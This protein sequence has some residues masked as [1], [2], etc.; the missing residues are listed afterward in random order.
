MYTIKKSYLLIIFLLV[1]V[2]RCAIQPISKP[3]TV[4]TVR[5]GIM[6]GEKNIEFRAENAVDVFTHDGSFLTS[7]IAGNRFLVSVIKSTAG[8]IEYRLLVKTVHDEQVAQ[9]IQTDV[10]AKGFSA[11]IKK[12][13]FKG[14][15]DG[16]LSSSVV[17]QVVLKQVF[18]TQD[19]A[20]RYRTNMNNALLTTVIPNFRKLP[21]GTVTLKNLNSGQMVESPAYLRVVGNRITLAVKVGTGFHFENTETR[22]Y[23]GIINFVIDRYGKL[24]MI[25]ELTLEAYLSGVVPSEMH[26]DF[27]LEALKAQSI[28]ARSYAVSRL[29]RQ[30]PLDPFD[31]CDDVHCQV[32]SGITRLS[33]N[34]DRAVKET[35]GQVLMYENSICETFYYAVC[36]GHTEHNENVW[37]GTP[38]RYLRGIFDL[39]Q[40]NVTVDEDFLMSESNMRTWIE[41]Q[42]NV[43][44]NV[45]LIEI[46]SYLEYTKK[47]FRW[48]VAYT[49]SELSQI[50]RQ[51]T[52]EDLGQIL[53]IV[54][55]ERGISGRLKKI[56]IEGT[57]KSITIEKELEIRRALSSNYLYSSCFIVDRVGSTGSVP[58]R[59]IIKGAGWGHGV[60][61]CQ[62]GAAVMALKG[63]DYQK[64]L[65]HYY[66]GSKIVS[67]Y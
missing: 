1:V 46:P 62:T 45:N 49:Q 33:P 25:N 22:S 2:S 9:Q 28:T 27:P 23:S 3:E 8:A 60:G 12:R 29:D 66:R 13:N 18:D 53:T 50:I 51:K 58:Q 64:I 17:Y 57:R 48:E 10:A 36:G 41:R 30:H 55:L 20:E 5:I 56:R 47:Y 15:H 4:L 14:I 40:E 52:G 6:E 26:P 31:L 35:A 43:Y 59:F 67:I 38:Q 54:P 37:Q 63:L 11:E 32:F 61:M 21:T 65:Q 42:P 24:T 16:K 39:P 34:A 7:G 19:A 44:C